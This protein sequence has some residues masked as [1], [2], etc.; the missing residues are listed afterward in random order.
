MRC[1]SESSFPRE[2]KVHQLVAQIVHSTQPQ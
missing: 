1:I 2:S